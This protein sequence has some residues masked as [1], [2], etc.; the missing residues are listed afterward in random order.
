M[1]KRS[2]A[3]NAGLVGV[4]L[5]AVSLL[6]FP[7]LLRFMARSE[8]ALIID[9][10][11]VS[12][13]P[14][15][16]IEGGTGGQLYVDGKRAHLDEPVVPGLHRIEWT[17]RYR[18]GHVRSVTH[19]QLVGPLQDPAKPS[20]S[21]SLLIAPSFLDETAPILEQLLV[22]QLK[23]VKQ[24]PIGEFEGASDVSMQWVKWNEDVPFKIRLKLAK[25]LPG[26]NIEGHLRVALAVEF[27]NANVSLTL[28]VVPL[29]K[30]AVLT[31]RVFVNASLDLDNRLFQWVADFFD[32]ND[33]VSNL[34]EREVRREMRNVLDKP[35]NIPLDGKT[36]LEIEFCEGEQ[37]H[38]HDA[39]H[40]AMPLALR[41]ADHF[42]GPPMH[43]I[44][45]ATTSAPMTTPL[46]IE[47]DR[48]ALGAVLHTLWNSGMLD[49]TLA[50]T[51]VRAFNEHPT[52]RDFLSL[53][54]DSAKFHLPPTIDFGEDGGLQLR[55][56]SRVSFR[57]GERKTDATLFAEFDIAA[58]FIRD[59]TQ[60]SKRKDPGIELKAAQLTCSDPSGRLRPCYSQIIAQVRANQSELQKQLAS[61]LRDLLLKL[62]TQRTLSAPGTPASYRLEST[63]FD[64]AGSRLRANL[65][66][67]VTR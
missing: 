40:V 38:F 4:L 8:L 42:P 61:L 66:G 53:R 50:S 55:A 36:S 7:S 11:D 59:P 56:A 1:S 26:A 35:P 58:E 65:R 6:A 29:I 3:R 63:D 20:C 32:G 25:E 37:L 5:T 39:G 60:A 44:R 41:V 13:G 67:V 21:L 17:R 64:V 62:F 24:W 23:G 48:N 15:I 12:K 28:T 9:A 33:R 57:D 49:R 18:G 47:L 2:R 22:K 31:F 46:A 27:E 43:P 14:Y 51:T 16:E 30:D 54:I 45:L 19:T 34:I 52:V 10:K